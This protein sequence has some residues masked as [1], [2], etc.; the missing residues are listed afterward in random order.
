M[1]LPS[2]Y[3]NWLDSIDTDVEVSYRG[4]EFYLLSERELIDEITIDKN[5]VKAFNQL[6]AFIK[7]QLEMS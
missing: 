7:T 1:I 4:S 2:Y 6:S 3:K 5:T